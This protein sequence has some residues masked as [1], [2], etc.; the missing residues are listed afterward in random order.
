VAAVGA[1]LQSREGKQLQKT[2]MRGVFGML[3]KK[4]Q[5]AAG[6]QSSRRAA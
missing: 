1:F 6:V 5:A 4:L 3:K 2:V